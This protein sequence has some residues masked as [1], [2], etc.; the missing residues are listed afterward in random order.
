MDGVFGF[1]R[2]IEKKRSIKETKKVGG[3]RK[4]ERMEKKREKFERKSG[5]NLGG[6]LLC[7]CG[8]RKP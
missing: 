7:Y 8:Q 3:A 5:K 2:E 1:D 4:I 6:G